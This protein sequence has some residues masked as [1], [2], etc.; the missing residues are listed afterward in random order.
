[1]DRLAALHVIANAIRSVM[2]DERNSRV[3]FAAMGEAI[4]RPLD[5]VP[6]PRLYRDIAQACRLLGLHVFTAHNNQ[7]SIQGIRLK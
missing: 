1:V 5:R 4:A 7:R 3:T 2:L 6:S